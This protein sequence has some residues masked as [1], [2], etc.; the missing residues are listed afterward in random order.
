MLDTRLAAALFQAVPSRA[1]LLLV[2]DIDQLP[3]VGPGNVLKD[4][5]TAST[6]RP[7]DPEPA[8]LPAAVTRLSVIYRQKEQSGIVTTA[9]AINSGDPTLPPAVPD[10][11]SVQAWADLTFVVATEAE[12]CVRKCIE[13]CTE[14][15]PRH[16]KWF[17]PVNDVQILA[18]MH[19]GVAG[20]AN[21]NVQLQ[22]A[23]NGAPGAAAHRG[24][25]GLRTANGEF[26]PGDKVIQLRNNYDKN[27]FNG[28]IGNVTAV[29]PSAGKLEAAFDGDRHEFTRGEFG[30]LALAY[31][32]SIHKSQGS[33][34]PVVIVPLLKAHF[35]M[36]Q[37]NLLYT[38][39][40]R[41]KKKVFLVGE[42]A[43]YAMAVRNSESKQRLTH[44]RE[45][46]AALLA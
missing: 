24:G 18:P 33:E 35:M 3:S 16:W 26:R 13:L 40:T 34:Y 15:I 9:H 12:D 7:S 2:G 36:L 46:I 19:K 37:R 44:L 23:L 29:E 30:D 28:D 25:G 32:I 4:L 42:P 21:L 8:V 41:G 10:V 11:A 31:A 43:A 45:K 5:I 20:V 17:D 1:H 22:G 14:F 27:L 6:P 38:A 39:I